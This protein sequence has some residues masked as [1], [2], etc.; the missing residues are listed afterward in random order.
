MNKV[1]FFLVVVIIFSCTINKKRL[2]TC[3]T[4]KEKALFSLLPYFERKANLKDIRLSDFEL[5]IWGFNPNDTM[6]DVLARYFLENGKM[7]ISFYSFHDKNKRILSFISHDDVI[8]DSFSVSYQSFLNLPI[9]I[10]DS[11]CTSYNLAKIKEFSTDSI[12]I[13]QLKIPDYKQIGY[14]LLEYVN[15]GECHRAYIRLPYNIEND[16]DTFP[17]FKAYAPYKNLMKFIDRSVEP[18]ILKKV[19]NI[20]K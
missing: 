15:K 5:R 17:E 16:Y 10:L 2:T 6:P 19:Q 4:I 12:V 7:N 1:L 9:S 13:R 18:I 8:K 20:E 11:L 14:T 3:I